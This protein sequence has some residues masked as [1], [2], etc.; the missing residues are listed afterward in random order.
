MRKTG[1]EPPAIEIDPNGKSHQALAIGDRA[2]ARFR[3]LSP[4]L[5]S[6]SIIRQLDP[7]AGR[8]L[9]LVI[10]TKQG[11]ILR[12]TDRKA[13]FDFDIAPDD[14]SGAKEGD[15]A[16]GEIRPSRGLARKKNPRP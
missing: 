5:Y 1:G 7:E 2:L 11:F 12:P 15:L 14:L 6:A 3:R 16:I 8:V 13:K 4:N 10:R 9:G